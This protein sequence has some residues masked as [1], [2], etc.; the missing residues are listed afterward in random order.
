[1]GR[2]AFR[3]NLRLPGKVDGICQN[4]RRLLWTVEAGAVL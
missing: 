2:G 4:A 3:Q 1:L